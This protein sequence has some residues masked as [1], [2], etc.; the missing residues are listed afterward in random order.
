MFILGDITSTCAIRSEPALGQ[1]TRRNHIDKWPSQPE[2]E[3]T[4][5]VTGLSGLMPGEDYSGRCREKLVQGRPG[6]DEGSLLAPSD[7]VQTIYPLLLPS[8]CLSF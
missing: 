5:I 7:L 4:Q 2:T 6:G 8:P 3:D 1:A